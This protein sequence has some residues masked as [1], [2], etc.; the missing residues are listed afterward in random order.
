VEGLHARL[1]RKEDGSFWLSDQGS[2]AGTWINYCPVPTEGAPVEHGDLL[3]IGRIGF[4][5]TQREP[6]HPRKPVVVLL[7]PPA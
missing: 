3:N 2:V 5:F 4:R 1:I 7:E 6:H